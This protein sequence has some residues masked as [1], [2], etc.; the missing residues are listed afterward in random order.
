MAAYPRGRG[1]PVDVGG[2]LAVALA[3]E[4]LPALAG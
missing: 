2:N 1:L 4:E 3:E